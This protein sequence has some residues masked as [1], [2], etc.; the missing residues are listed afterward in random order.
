VKKC[1]ETYFCTAAWFF[2]GVLISLKTDGAVD[3]PLVCGTGIVALLV[4]VFYTVLSK[5]LVHNTAD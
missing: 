5:R 1:L 2:R 4:L 3:T